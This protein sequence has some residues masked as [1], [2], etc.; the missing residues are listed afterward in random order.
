MAEQDTASPTYTVERRADVRRMFDASATPLPEKLRA[1]AQEVAARV[2]RLDEDT[3]GPVTKGDHVGPYRILRPLGSGGQAF[4]YEAEHT[5]LG[6]RVALKVPRKDVAERL[7]REARISARLEHSRIVRVEHVGEHE[8]LGGP[9]P[10][11]VLEFL[12]GD[13]LDHRLEQ[14]PAGLPLEEV[15]RIGEAILEGLAYAHAQGIVHRDVKPSNVLF[16]ANDE[17][18]IADLGIGTQATGPDLDHSIDRTQLTAE[19]A[20][21]GTPMF[22]APEQEDPSLLAGGSIDGRADLFS[23]GKMLFVMLTGASPRTIR[24]PS[25]MRPGLDPRWDDL[26]FKLL[27][28]DRELRHADAEEALAA[29]R[30]APDGR[31]I[32]VEVR[33]LTDSGEEPAI[34]VTEKGRVPVGT[35]VFDPA[36]SVP[37]GW[38]SKVFGLGALA[39]AGFAGFL[40]FV[41]SHQTGWTQ[42]EMLPLLLASIL[43]TPA[44]LLLRRGEKLTGYGLGGG[45]AAIPAALLAGWQPALF[46]GRWAAQVPGI[47]NIGHSD[48]IGLGVVLTVLTAIFALGLTLAY[49]WRRKTQ[50]RAALREAERWYYSSDAYVPG[51]RD[52]AVSY[53][54]W[55]FLGF[56]GAHRFYLGRPF[57][58]LLWFFT[59]G[60][61]G[62]GWLV[63][64]FWTYHMVEVENARALV[65]AHR[66][67]RRLAA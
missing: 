38:G 14:F 1:E 29:L 30:A 16:D 15:K 17:P 46:F 32:R 58:G 24:P 8:A 41:A 10:Y 54:L 28:E 65:H 23:F 51:Q 26:L 48:F 35:I 57:T 21:I 60:L 13:S 22:M 4:V 61:V 55:A 56:F 33:P 64:A 67:Q 5:E 59:G 19:G 47:A 12:E 62:I 11:L 45:L 52:M 9:L 34:R 43:A 7:L 49:R 3:R 50:E 66:R 6:R 20:V 25:R 18:K 44:L 36:E 37:R 31:P 63:D 2:F 40:A 27:E 53:L 42:K 39:S